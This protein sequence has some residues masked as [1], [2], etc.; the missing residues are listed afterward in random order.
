MCDGQLLWW[1]L[2]L[3]QWKWRER[4]QNYK[5][6]VLSLQLHSEGTSIQTITGFVTHDLIQQKGNLIDN[7][8]LLFRNWILSLCRW[9]F[10]L[11]LMMQLCKL[12]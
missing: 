12:G 3:G 8:F 1:T 9:E 2:E 6:K 5:N 11:I 10:N 7:R 4:K